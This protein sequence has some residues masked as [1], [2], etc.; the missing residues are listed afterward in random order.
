MSVVVYGLLWSGLAMAR[1][2]GRA[3]VEVT[4]IARDPHEFGLRSR[5]LARR[6]RAASDEEV[7]AAIPE[8][9][10]LFPERDAHVAF[11]LRHWDAVRERAAVPFP[12]DPEIVRRLRSKDLLPAEAE[13]AGVPV[14]RTTSDGLD[15]LEPPFLVKPI[16]GQEFAARFGE[17]LF[18]AADLDAAVAA[19]QLAADAG[20]HTVVQ[21]LVPDARDKVYSLFAYVGQAGEPL[22]TV[23]GRKLRAGPP[24]FGTAAVFELMEEPRVLETGLRLLRSSGYKGFAQVELVHD[25]RDDTFKLLEVNTRPP[26]WGGIAMTDRY[27]VARLA[28]DDLRGEP[29]EPLPTFAEEGVRWIYM[30]KDV[31]S[32][33]QLARE[34]ELGP[35]GFARPYLRGP[36]KVRAILARDDLR[37]ALAS[38]AYLRAKVP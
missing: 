6:V 14:P 5:Y 22:A 8:G 2:L 30:A 36:G 34:R 3:G 20:F 1:S 33:L 15:G 38:L 31:W 28:Y 19:R 17:K 16:E 37:P 26:Q 35:V 4:G 11:V 29:V 13:K 9:S 24:H 7:L 10:V 27:D 21:E 18:V 32:S 12:D 25:A 23:T